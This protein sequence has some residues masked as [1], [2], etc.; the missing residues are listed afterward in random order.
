MGLKKY[1]VDSACTVTSS[2]VGTVTTM[3]SANTWGHRYWETT[4]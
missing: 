1:Y 4:T 2:Y 3:P